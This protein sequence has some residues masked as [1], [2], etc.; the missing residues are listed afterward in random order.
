[1]SP[2]PDF[3][4]DTGDMVMDSM[5][6]YKLYEKIMSELK[7]P[8]ICA[9]GNHDKPEGLD[10]ADLAMSHRG[11]MPYYAFNHKGYSFYILDAN[12]IERAVKGNITED[13]IIWLKK[14]LDMKTDKPCF[15]FL[16]HD[17]FSG[18]GAKNYREVR[19]N[20]EK[21]DSGVDTFD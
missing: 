11:L 17:L 6:S 18:R 20:T 15:F 2:L 13:Q 8:W 10:I 1:M 19:E 3:V 14:A 5:E 9:F 12:D 21:Y 7:I 4:V 16:H